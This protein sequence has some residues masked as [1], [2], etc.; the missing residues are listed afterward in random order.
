MAKTFYFGRSRNE[1]SHGRDGTNEEAD[2]LNDV[3]MFQNDFAG[4]NICQ[5]HLKMPCSCKYMS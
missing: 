5:S 3:G 1:K 4:I 2:K